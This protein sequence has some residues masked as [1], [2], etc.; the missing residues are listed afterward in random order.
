M[1]VCFPRKMLAATTEK[2]R[3]NGTSVASITTR[4]R[5]VVLALAMYVVRTIVSSISFLVFLHIG[6]AG[7]KYWILLSR[8]YKIILLML[9]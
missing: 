2:E 9:L 7:A 4:L 8:K 6:F 3:P 1:L 5:S